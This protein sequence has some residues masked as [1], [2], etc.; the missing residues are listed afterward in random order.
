[1]AVSITSAAHLLL[2]DDDQLL[3]IRRHNTGYEDGNYS[4]VAGHIEH[5]EPARQAMVREAR[6]EANIDLDIDDLDF[7]HMM[8][9]LSDGI[10]R[11]DL[12]FECARWAGTVENVEP[13][14]CDA[15]TW[16]PC[17]N[18]PDN[19]IPYVRTALEH[20]AAGRTF[21]EFGWPVLE[22]SPS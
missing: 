5:G 22:H 20:I 21:S 10:V 9:R 18:L 2:H 16:Y 15:M 4:V 14:K 12:F 8:Y 7:A 17:R 19:T 11:V 3:M 1:M 6:E 13:H